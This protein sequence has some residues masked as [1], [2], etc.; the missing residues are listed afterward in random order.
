MAIE[1]IDIV[2]P[3]NNPL[4]EIEK[5]LE[6]KALKKENSS[7]KTK[8]EALRANNNSFLYAALIK[9]QSEMPIVIK[10]S[11]VYGKQKFASF[12][13]IKKLAHPILSKNG[14]FVGQELTSIDGKEAIKTYICHASGQCRESTFI[15]PI[16]IGEKTLNPRNEVAGSITFFMRRTFSATLGIVT[17]EAQED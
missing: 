16:F 9:F 6:L 15:V 12:A 17:E 14:L 7:L 5:E 4:E 8:I 11:T 13:Y 1:Q 10:D 3:E 2:E